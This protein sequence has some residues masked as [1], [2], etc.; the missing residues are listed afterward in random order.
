[1]LNEGHSG[2]ERCVRTR[3]IG[4][5]MLPAGHAAGC[6]Y[7]AMEALFNH[8]HTPT[9]STTFEPTGYFEQPEMHAFARAALDLGW[10]LVAYEALVAVDADD[11]PNFHG[12]EFVN[13]RERRQA[14]NI[15]AALGAIPLDARRL[16]WCGNSHH[17]K[18]P[19]PPWVSMGT[20]VVALGGDPFCIDQLAT[21]SLGPDSP[22]NHP[23][24]PELSSTLDA[25]GGTAGFLRDAP[26][27]GFHVPDGWDAL[28]FSTDNRFE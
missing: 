27:D 9:F 5:E 21:V 11:E 22:A 23:L 12:I 25:L 7:L 10:Q 6:R 3:R 24:T 16:V 20:H 2:M 19:R 28:I 1:M 18:C 14:E 8:E 15:V 13:W 26:P 4:L 17:V